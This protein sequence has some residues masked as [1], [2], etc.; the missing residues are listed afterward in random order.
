MK[1]LLPGI[2]VILICQ[3][4]G[5][6]IQSPAGDLRAK[7]HVLKSTADCRE[8]RF[9]II[10]LR[11]IKGYPGGSLGDIR[12]YRDLIDEDLVKLFLCPGL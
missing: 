3:I 6:D 9:L 4:G 1:I 10:L 11:Q 5:G 8:D 7:L 12:I 2:K